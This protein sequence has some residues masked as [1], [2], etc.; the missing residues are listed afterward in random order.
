MKWDDKRRVLSFMHIKGSYEG[1]MNERNFNIVLVE[2]GNGVGL[3]GET[4]TKSV[5][6]NGERVDIELP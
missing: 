6:Y 4:F 1:M 3:D 5:K 2:N